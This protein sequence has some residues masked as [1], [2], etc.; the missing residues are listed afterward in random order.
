MQPSRSDTQ[1]TLSVCP[2]KMWRWSVAQSKVTN[3]GGYFCILETWTLRENLTYRASFGRDGSHLGCTSPTYFSYVQLKLK[4]KAISSFDYNL[5]PKQLNL[6]NNITL[7]VTIGKNSYTYVATPRKLSWQFIYIET[8]E[9]RQAAT[10]EWNWWTI[11]CTSLRS[12][13]SPKQIK[14]KKQEKSCFF[15]I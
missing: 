7:S 6:L 4:D 14:T 1:G 3:S 15:G 11:I 9:R 12:I 10:M 13:S 8:I 5:I 2:L